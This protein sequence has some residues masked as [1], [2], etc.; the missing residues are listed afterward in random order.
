MRSKHIAA[1]ITFFA[2]FA[3]SAFI[4]LLF[5]AP[6]ISDVPPVKDYEFKS[7]NNGCRKNTGYRIKEFLTRDKQNGSSLDNYRLLYEDGFVSRKSLVLFADGVSEYVAESGSMDASGFP[8]DFQGAWHAH[9]I[10]WSDYA[11]FLQDS[12]YKQMTFEEFNERADEYNS[13]ISVTWYEALRVAR[14]NGAALPA[15]F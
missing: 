6:K 11:D 9:M 1:L 10:A 13:E 15:G 14:E 12:K 7:F 3:F 2:T 8:R 4:A 5:A